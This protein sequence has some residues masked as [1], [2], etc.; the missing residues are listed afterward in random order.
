M[1]KKDKDESD[2][3]ITMIRYGKDNLSKGV[4]FDELE[5][6]LKDKEFKPEREKDDLLWVH[7]FRD[8]YYN[9][10]SGTKD[11]GGFSIHEKC[12]LRIESYFKLLEYDEL[13]EARQSAKSAKLTAIIA[14]FISTITF[15]FLLVFLFIKLIAQQMFA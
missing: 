4:K 8:I 14:I 10:K 15:Y 9:P 13:N 12:F 5:K 1:R 11:I 3:Y 6:H 7:S 2:L